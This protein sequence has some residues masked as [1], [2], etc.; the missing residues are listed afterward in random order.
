MKAIVGAGKRASAAPRE[1]HPESLWL[2]DYI[3]GFMKQPSWRT[4]IEEFVEQHF[5][6]FAEEIDLATEQ[7]HEHKEVHK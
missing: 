4:P 1:A 6:L 2:V 7:P 3:T 5:S